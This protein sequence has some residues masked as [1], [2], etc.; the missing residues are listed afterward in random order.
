MA[1]INLIE[2]LAY[3]DPADLTYQD[4]TNVGMGL[5]EAGYPASAWEDW[6]RRDGSRYHPG[7]CLRK[8]E[9]FRGNGTPVTGGTIVQMA[10]ERGWGRSVELDWDSE[11]SYDGEIDIG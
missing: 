11:I 9:T 5:K 3:I 10:R 4:W 1:E 7:E 6:S 2:C 8:W